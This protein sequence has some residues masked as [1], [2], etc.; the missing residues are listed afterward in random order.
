M[1]PTRKQKNTQNPSKFSSRRSSNINTAGKILIPTLMNFQISV[2]TLSKLRNNKTHICSNSEFVEQSTQLATSVAKLITVNR[3]VSTSQVIVNNSAYIT[4]H[5]NPAST[6]GSWCKSK[7]PK[8]STGFA[9]AFSHTCKLILPVSICV[10]SI[11]PVFCMFLIQTL[12]NMQNPSKFFNLSSSGSHQLGRQQLQSEHQDTTRVNTN[13]AGNTLLLILVNF[14]LNCKS[15]SKTLPQILKL[16]RNL[17][18]GFSCLHSNL[19]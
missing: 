10:Y 15:E 3:K 9:T 17:L 1:I 6:S 19:K 8:T 12:K 13:I 14:D 5:A 16:T 4:K 18:K 2:Q 7:Q 11:Q